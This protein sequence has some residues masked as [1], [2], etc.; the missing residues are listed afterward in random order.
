M[1]YTSH[2][3]LEYPEGKVENGE[4]LMEAISLINDISRLGR[5]FDLLSFL[6]EGKIICH[7]LAKKIHLNEL[8]NYVAVV[9]SRSLKNLLVPNRD[10]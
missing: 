7:Y 3:L 2:V 6:K 1:R 9:T 10:F 4:K 8:L 5:P